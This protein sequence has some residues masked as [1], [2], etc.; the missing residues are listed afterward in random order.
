MFT[1]LGAD[2]KEYGPV[3]AGKVI[4][5][6]QGGR[7]NAQTKIKRVDATE[8]ITIGA[9]PEFGGS[10]GN[11]S[12]VPPALPPAA[13]PAS[14]PAVPASLTGSA[15]DIAA[16]LNARAAPLEVFGCLGRSFDL[17]K[18]NFLPL[19]GVTLLILLVQMVVSLIPFLGTLSGFFLNG[20]FTGGLYYYYLGIMRGEHRAVGDAFA[21]FSRAFVPLMLAT[22]LTSILIIA[23]LLVFLGPLFLSLVKAMMLSGRVVDSL[24]ALSPLALGGIFLGCIA[25]LYLSISWVFTFALVIDQ[26]LGPW[27][28]MEVSRRVVT[29][30][31]FRV[32]FVM[33]LG[34]IL[35]MLGLI[36][37]FIGVFF[38]IPLM[39]GAVL[40]AYE[41]LFNPPA[42]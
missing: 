1:I 36:G 26:G 11:Q 38:T 25:M 5:W 41:D 39:F 34:V 8:W 17:W 12:A 10:D 33:L 31:W 21:G 29:R 19:V 24:P 32:F 2:G 7:A 27:T 16:G 40:Y 14:A 4:E 22:L 30:Q 6:M 20:V 15:G 18:S 35:A 3:T 42:A 23:V 13:A 9:L 28:A 37:L